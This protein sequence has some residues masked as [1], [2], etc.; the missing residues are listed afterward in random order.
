MRHPN[1]ISSSSYA[2]A[3]CPVCQQISTA[4]R[5]NNGE[6]IMSPHNPLGPQCDGVAQTPQ[7]IVHVHDNYCE[8]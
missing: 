8:Q 6:W 2:D 3:V 5:L 4:I 1:A 7:E